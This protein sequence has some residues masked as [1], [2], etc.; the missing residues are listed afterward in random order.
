MKVGDYIRTKHGIIT[1]IIGNR[2]NPYGEETIFKL[3]KEISIYDLE[4]S[5]IYLMTNPLAKDTINEIDMHFGDEKI[6]KKSSPNIINLIE[7]GDYVNGRKVYQVGYNFQD[8]YVLKMSESNYEDFIYPN[9]I[10]D[11]ITKEQFKS[12][13]YKVK[14]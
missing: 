7:V 12:M 13:E 5:D 11:I 8:D 1:K 10:K 6:I 3:D 9:E 2:K 14:E 4:L